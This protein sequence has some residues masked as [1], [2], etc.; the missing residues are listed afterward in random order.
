MK[1]FIS[2]FSLFFGLGCVNLHSQS[3]TSSEMHELAIQ[4]TPKGLAQLSEFISINNNS[5]NLSTLDKNLNWSINKLQNLGFKAQIIT[6]DSVPIVLASKIVNPS[7]PTVLF[8]MQIDGQPVTQSKWDQQDPYKLTLKKEDKEGLWIE[9]DPSK[10]EK[11]DKNWRVFG[12]STSDSKGPSIALL[13]A[14][15]IL[16]NKRI[17]PAFNIKLLLDFQEELG[18]PTLPKAVRENEE[19]FECDYLLIMDGTRDVSNLPTLTFGAR[20][21]A[22]ATLTFYGAEENLHSG[23]YGNYAP[24]PVFSAAK[25]IG[26]LKDSIGRVTLEGYYDGI[27][28]DDTLKEDLAKASQNSSLLNQRLGI[29]REEKVGVNYQEAMQYPSLNVRGIKSGWVGNEVRTIIPNT[30][31]VEIDMRLVLESDG[32][33]LVKLL[34]NRLKSQGFQLVDDTPSKQDRLKY[35][36]LVSIKYKL[37]SRAYRTE[38]NHPIREYLDRAFVPLFNNNYIITRTTG[39]SQP[40]APFVNQLN[41]PAVS[42]RIPNPDNNIH[43]PNENL[44]IGNFTEGIASCLSILQTP[45]IHT[46]DK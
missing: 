3:L 20:G 32:E 46:Y 26:S 31:E 25:F 10:M 42:I 1:I 17:S 35:P 13:S 36:K 43:G 2:V 40:I 33:T 5:R 7:L 15:D 14:F 16:K 6:T 28:L 24:N 4:Y 39:G 27:H 22:T 29:A 30:V 41:I 34:K 21:I 45:I 37:G 38:L 19:L 18:S 11:P 23:Q 44:R 8:Y 12:R 9:L